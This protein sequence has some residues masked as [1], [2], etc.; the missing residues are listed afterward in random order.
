MNPPIPPLPTASPLGAPEQRVVVE[1]LP[2]QI[3][4]VLRHRIVHGLMKAGSRIAINDLTEEFGTS[5]TPVR[6]ALNRLE[7]DQLIVTRPRSGTFVVQP[8]ADDV[9]EVCQLRKGIEWVATGL[10][11][12]TM[13]EALL[14]EL[15]EE[16]VA[17]KRHA[18]EGDYE[19]FFESDYRLHNLI[20]THAGNTRLVRARS[21]VEPFVQW[22]RVLGATGPHRIAGSTRRHLEIVDAMLDRDAEAAMTAAALH[23]D[24]VQRWTV[25]D[26]G[27]ALGGD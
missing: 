3:Y 11:A 27:S 26:L 6:E 22:L 15:R 25:E 12:R 4:R 19:P 24:E 9:V 17:A 16:I 2:D 20:V 14:R 13:P 7:Y 1:K 21:S 8:T 23:V 18:D 5:K 10:S